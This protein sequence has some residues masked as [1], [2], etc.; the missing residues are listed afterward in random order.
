MVEGQN[1][2]KRRLV[3]VLA[4]KNKLRL[5]PWAQSLQSL[6]FHSIPFWAPY[7][8]FWPVNPE[9]LDDNDEHKLGVMMQ[10]LVYDSKVSHL[11]D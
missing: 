11:G 3:I 1:P 4:K 2:L 8:S 5:H 7:Y 10:H 6:C 9:C